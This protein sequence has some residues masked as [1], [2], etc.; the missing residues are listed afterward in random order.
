MSNVYLVGA[1]CGEPDLLTIKGQKAIA[2]AGVLIYD[3]LANPSLLSYA[4]EGCEKIYVGKQAGKHTMRQEDINQLIVDKAMAGKTVVRLKG[5]DPYVFGRGGEEGEALAAAGIAFEVVPGITS[6]IGGLA[7]AGIPVTHRGMATSFHVI[8]GH[9]QPS[10]DSLDYDIYAK[11]KGTL[12][13]LMGIGNIENICSGLQKGGM[14]ADAPAAV[15]HRASSP[16]QRT[17]VG[18]LGTLAHDAAE[19]GITA[20]GLIVIGD[21]VTKRDALSFFEKKPLF[22]KKIIVT[23][24]RAQSS[25]LMERISELGGQSIEMPMIETRP[26]QAERLSAEI[27]RLANYTYVIFTSENGVDIFFD[28]LRKAGKDARALGKAKIA[29]IGKGTAKALEAHGIAADYMPWEFVGEA[30]VDMLKNILKPDDK[31]LIPRAGNARPYLV[32]TLKKI[33]PVTEI[34]IYETVRADAD[35]SA[36]KAMLACGEIDY[37]TFASSSTVEN[38]VAEMGE[39]AQSKLGGAK[40]ISIGPQTSQKIEEHGLCVY[41]QANEYTIDGILEVLK[42]DQ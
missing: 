15:V 5:G 16:M 4:K 29:V 10:S 19:N 33:A 28:A 31:I 2:K 7:Y 22:G 34:K 1:G 40:L 38:F 8:T 42:G 36:V 37:I 27:A 30:L 39:K 23:R 9:R 41:A 35:Y 6:V 25:Q 17:V 12:V 11:L 32:D 21:V 26:I 24:A 13:F 18:T 20:P 3:W 14:D